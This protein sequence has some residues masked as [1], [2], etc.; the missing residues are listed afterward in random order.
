MIIK[1]SAMLPPFQLL[2]QFL[3][4]IGFTIL[5]SS[6]ALAK[7]FLEEINSVARQSKVLIAP[8]SRIN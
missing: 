3:F 8:C 1:E 4:G 5:I 6:P 2:E 7:L